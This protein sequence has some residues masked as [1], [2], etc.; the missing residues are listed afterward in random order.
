MLRLCCELSKLISGP[1]WGF[2]RGRPRAR[3]WEPRGALDKVFA[4]LGGFMQ[5]Q[6]EANAGAL[7]ARR[8][9]LHRAEA[10]LNSLKRLLS[11]RGDWGRASRKRD[12][13][14]MRCVCVCVRLC[15]EGRKGVQTWV[16]GTW[17]TSGVGAAVRGRAGEETRGRLPSGRWAGGATWDKQAPGRKV[18][19][20][21]GPG[22]LA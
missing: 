9:H 17:R 16:A 20:V 8:R 11:R 10:Y 19:W 18:I 21:R 2:R 1:A 7:R 13:C 4:S 22:S 5:N 15:G 14:M 12:A 6:M 3:D